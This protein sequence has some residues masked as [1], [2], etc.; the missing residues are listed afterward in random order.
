MH[1]FDFDGLPQYGEAVAGPGEETYGELWN[2]IYLGNLSPNGPR[3]V[4]ERFRHLQNV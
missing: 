2:W 1:F 3:E 4:A